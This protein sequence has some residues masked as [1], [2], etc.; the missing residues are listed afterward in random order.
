MKTEDLLSLLFIASVMLAPYIANFIQNN[1]QPKIVY[2]EKEVK[3]KK[4]KPK[5]IIKQPVVID[6]PIYD[7]CVEFLI[8][9]GMNKAKSKQ[10]VDNLFNNKKYNTVQ[11][12]ILDAYKIS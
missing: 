11:D 3:I 2:I 7:D 12:F 5:K 9:M 4:V 8:S 10:K 6:N 1:Q